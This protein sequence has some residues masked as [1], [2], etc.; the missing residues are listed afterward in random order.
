MKWYKMSVEGGS[1]RALYN[2]GWYYAYGVGV[3]KDENVAI[4]YW[5]KAAAAG[6]EN[7]K[8]SLKLRGIE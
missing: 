1:T 5:K 8:E 4:E 6:D 3:E 7:A 2:L